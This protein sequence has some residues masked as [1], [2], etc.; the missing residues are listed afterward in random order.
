MRSI[1]FK[2]YLFEWKIIKLDTTKLCRPQQTNHQSNV[3]ENIT[4]L[5]KIT[6]LGKSKEL[7]EGSAQVQ[8]METQTLKETQK[9]E[10]KHIYVKKNQL[11]PKH[12]CESML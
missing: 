12:E 4:R 10:Q 2:K 5:T 11:Y 7:S 8:D 9:Q 1:S 6:H 3:H